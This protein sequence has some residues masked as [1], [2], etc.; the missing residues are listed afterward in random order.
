VPAKPP[1]DREQGRSG[2]KNQAE[3]RHDLSIPHQRLSEVFQKGKNVFTFH[4]VQKKHCLL[5][6]TPRMHRRP[7]NERWQNRT[8]GGAGDD[9]QITT[10][11]T[12]ACASI[13]LEGEDYGSKVSINVPVRRRRYAVRCNRSLAPSF[14]SLPAPSLP[15]KTRFLHSFCHILECCV[16]ILCT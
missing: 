4:P 6:Y 8:L 16:I 13:I 2:K 7:H 5:N 3:E 14:H 15:L 10:S 11:P 1:E 12:N 9:L